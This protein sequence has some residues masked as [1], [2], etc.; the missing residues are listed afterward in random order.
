[1]PSRPGDAPCRYDENRFVTF[2]MTEER[3]SQPLV[4]DTASSLG[5]M[6]QHFYAGFRKL[7][8]QRDNTNNEANTQH[9][10]HKRINLQPR[11][12]IGIKSQHRAAA[13]TG[14]RGTRRRRPG[15]GDFVG[16]VGGSFA[17][18]GGGGPARGFGGRGAGAGGAGCGGLGSGLCG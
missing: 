2:A 14:A 8:M 1:M 11:A 6:A 7:T 12:L 13:A 16:T 9:H 3:T 17:A 18:D 15:I 10:H 5:L 4:I